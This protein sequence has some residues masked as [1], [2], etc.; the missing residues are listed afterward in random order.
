MIASHG[1]ASQPSSAQPN[2][3]TLA[4]VRRLLREA[5]LIDG[6]NDLPWQYRKHSND[7]SAIDLRHDTSKLS[8]PLIT[9]IPRLRAGGVGAQFWAVYVPPE[10]GGPTGVQMMFEQIDAS[11]GKAGSPR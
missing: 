9:D 5:P 8:P 2:P 1:A 11:I 7:F 6:H 4:E 3:A 10:P